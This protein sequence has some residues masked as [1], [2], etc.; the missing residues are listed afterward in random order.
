[1]SNIL[2]YKGYH[3]KIKY[4]AESGML[5]GIIEGICDFVNFES[6][7]L[8]TIESEFHSAVD[9]YLL[10]CEEV[11]KNPEKEYKGSFNIRIAPS[12]HRRLAI[13]A[14][15]KDMSLNQLV[16]IALN[17]YFSEKKPQSSTVVY[18]KGNETK[19]TYQLPPFSLNAPIWG[20]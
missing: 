4:D 3:T 1:M 6:D 20:V 10:F 16:E 13:E 19:S 2:E 8:E 12:L 11:G 14:N 7:S 5:H 18:V 17:D 9:D 15:K